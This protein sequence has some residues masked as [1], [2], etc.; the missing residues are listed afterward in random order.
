MSKVIS[1]SPTR[2]GRREGAG[3]KPGLGPWGEKTIPVRI[4]LSQKQNVLA[5]LHRQKAQPVTSLPAEALLPAI[6]PVRLSVPL[7]SNR[8]AAGFPSP[9]DDYI[10]NR[11]DLN[12]LLIRN[13][14]AT[15]FLKVKGHS[16]KNAGIFDGDTIVVDR[17]LDIRHHHIVVA[18]VDGELTVK[19][20]SMEQGRTRLVAENP[21]FPDIEL[22]EG[23]ELVIWGV[24]TNVIHPVK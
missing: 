18:A 11:L 7:F 1:Q 22:K 10:E 24:V 20:L 4:P 13:P 9:A 14:A 16:M 19:R 6:E 2:G 8:I 21:E 5:F 15:F 3:R 23:Q 12:Q 17:S